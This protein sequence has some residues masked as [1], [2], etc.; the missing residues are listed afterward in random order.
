MGPSLTDRI[1]QAL[2]RKLQVAITNVHVRIQ[3]SSDPSSRAGGVMIRAVR[4]DDARDPTP[5]PRRRP[6]RVRMSRRRP[7]ARAHMTKTVL[8][9]MAGPI[10][11]LP[12]GSGR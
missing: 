4:V 12:C 10:T 6:V 8:R 5:P 1:V 9:L 3:G 2:I 11:C 7:I